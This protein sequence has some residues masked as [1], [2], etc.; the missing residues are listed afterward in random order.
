M[1]DL[2]LPARKGGQQQEAPTSCSA[3][4]NFGLNFL[5]MMTLVTHL[6]YGKGVICNG[7]LNSVVEK[8]L[9]HC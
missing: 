2:L 6:N 8:D 7:D 1:A 5:P 9:K 4:S 3:T